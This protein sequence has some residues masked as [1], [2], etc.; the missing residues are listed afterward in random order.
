MMSAGQPQ[1]G[2]R[3]TL[4]VCSVASRAAS[5]PASPLPLT[6]TRNG[7]PR[8]EIDGEG[9]YHNHILYAAHRDRN[10]ICH[11]RFL[12]ILRCSLFFPL[13]HLIRDSG[14]VRN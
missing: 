13:I 7:I 5:A 2:V 11:S 3:A 12:G 4:F 10:S 14:N 6:A 8:A 9:T 1:I